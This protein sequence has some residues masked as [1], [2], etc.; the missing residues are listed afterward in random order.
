[1]AMRNFFVPWGKSVPD[2]PKTAFK[3]AAPAADVGEDELPPGIE[4]LVLWEPPDDSDPKIKPVIVDNML[5]KWLR[6]HQREGCDC[7]VFFL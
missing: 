6:P 1:M 7:R 4:P 3:P 2:M 5:T